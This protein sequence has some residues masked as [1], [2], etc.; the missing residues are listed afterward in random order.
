MAKNQVYSDFVNFDFQTGHKAFF[1]DIRH[2]CNTDFSSSDTRGTKDMK[3]TAGKL[4]YRRCTIN[5]FCVQ[6]RLQK[7]KQMQTEQPL[8]KI[9]RIV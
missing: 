1:T 6:V 3:K 5:S 7:N 4:D 8:F 2:S 9:Y